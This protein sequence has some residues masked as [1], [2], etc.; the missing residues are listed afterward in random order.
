MYLQGTKGIWL[1]LADGLDNLIAPAKAV[2][3]MFMYV[4]M[5]LDWFLF[6]N[7]VGNLTGRV[8]VPPCREGIHHAYILDR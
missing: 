2:S 4:T 8:C 7:L 1:K 5:V 6:S 3:K